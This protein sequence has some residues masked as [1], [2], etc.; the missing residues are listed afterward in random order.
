MCRL[1]GFLLAGAAVR[2]IGNSIYFD[3]V[4]NAIIWH[5][6]AGDVLD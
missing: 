6:R 4:V 3:C 1:F 5:L 2:F